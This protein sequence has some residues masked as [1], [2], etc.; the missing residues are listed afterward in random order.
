MHRPPLIVRL[1]FLLVVLGIVGGAAWWYFNLR[2]QPDGRLSASGTIEADT[3]TIGA[4]VPGRVA[5]VTAGEG[6][7]VSAGVALVILDGTTLQAQREQAAA[8][9]DAADANVAAA[10]A[11]AA[12]AASAAEA[13]QANR[14][15]L[16]AGPSVEQLAV[17]QANVDAAE[18]AVDNLE[19]AYSE[20]SRAARDTPAGRELKLQRDVA[21]ANLQTA[22]AQLAL[23]QAGARPEQIEAARAQ[24]DAAR[25]QAGAAAEQ[26][27]A[28]NAHAGAARAMLAAIDSQV[29]Q[30]SV[31]SPIDGVVLTRAI[32]PGEYAAPGAPLMVIG[33]LDALEITVYVPE[34]RYGILNLGQTAEVRVDSF[35]DRA[36]TGRIVHISNEFEFTPRNVQTPEGRRSTVFAIK[37]AVDNPEGLLK[38]GM[39]ADLAF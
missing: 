37:L 10:E 14:E 16:E 22:L 8:A 34:D 6:D 27:A 24:A 31:N 1:V 5:E 29:A 36:F 4:Q 20:L 2:E 17:A 25:A 28:A 38:P 35:A 30:L 23:T 33:N 12:A 11:T 9:V 3:V 26:V 21:R 32:E 7:A 39:P 13:A 19:D 15:L 18:V